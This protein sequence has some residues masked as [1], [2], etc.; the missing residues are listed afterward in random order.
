MSHKS[1][2]MAVPKTLVTAPLQAVD[3]A[4]AGAAIFGIPERYVF[5]G[6]R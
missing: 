1:Q 2:V 3:S 5:G 4:R 6:T